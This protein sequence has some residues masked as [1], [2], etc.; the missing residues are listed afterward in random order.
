MR[1]Q[2][3]DFIVE[4]QLGFEPEGEGEH[5]FLL[6]EKRAANT[7]FVAEQLAKLLRVPLRQVSFSGMKDRY[8][9]TRQW[10]SVHYPGRDNPAIGQLHGAEYRVLNV[11]RHL[12]KLRRGVH[13]GNLFRIVLRDVKGDIAGLTSRIQRLTAHGIPNYFGEQRFGRSGDNVAQAQRWLAGEIS[14]RRSLQG[15][16]LSSIRAH[17]FNQNLAKRVSD[18]S[19]C[20]LLDGELV[21]LEGSQSIFLNDGSPLQARL[22]HGDVHPTGPLWGKPGKLQPQGGAAEY[23]RLNSEVDKNLYEG[24]LAK[25]LTAERRSLRVIPRHFQSQEQADGSLMFSFVLPRGSYA[26]AVLREMCC[27]QTVVPASHG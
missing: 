3:E 10:F 25:G 2:C 4:E 18:G 9:V 11:T 22:E 19:W 5:L 24:L 20:Q 8:A 21:M 26:T 23:E 27:Y 17:L 1:Q 6:I 16:Y 14:P 13:K 7:Q 15:L 12:R